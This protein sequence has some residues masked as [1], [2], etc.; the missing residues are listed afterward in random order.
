MT[1]TT[2][3]E[4][5]TADSSRIARYREAEHALFSAYGLSRPSGSSISLSRACGCGFSR[6]DRAKL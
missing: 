5:A 2:T 1:A 4:A 6:S 3:L